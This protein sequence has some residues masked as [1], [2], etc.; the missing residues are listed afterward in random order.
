[1]GTGLAETIGSYMAKEFRTLYCIIGDGSTLM[2]IQDLQSISD[3]KIPCVICVINNNGYLAIRRTQQGFLENRYYG[4]HP[5]WKLGIVDFKDAAKAFK[6]Q[7]FK[8]DENK[9]IDSMCKKVL[10]TKK[11]ILLEVLVSENQPALFS[12]QYVKNK[13]GTSTPK[14]LEHMK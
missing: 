14:S 7:Y 8:L 3:M 1:M 9:Q 5:D 2:N 4:T 13:D 12:Q 10:N 11:P 6:L